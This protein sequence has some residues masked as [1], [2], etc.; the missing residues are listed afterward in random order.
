MW[1]KKSQENE[2]FDL[3]ISQQMSPND[4]ELQRTGSI[5]EE[6]KIALKNS[7]YHFTLTFTGQSH[8]FRQSPGVEKLE[9]EYET[10]PMWEKKKNSII[11]WLERLKSEL[12]QPDKWNEYY[13]VSAQ[14]NWKFNDDKD[15]LK[16]NYGEIEEITKSINQIKTQIRQLE[17]P[18]EK[19]GIIENKLDYLLVKS[20]LLGKFDWKNLFVG[21]IIGLIVQLALPVNLTQQIWTIIGQAFKQFILIALK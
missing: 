18:A 19:L 17:L 7:N 3:I 6:T 9:E 12:E 16:F 4:F 11:K 21:T 1:L 20:K 8:T 15:N 13:L 2:I 14:V 10:Y 5:Y